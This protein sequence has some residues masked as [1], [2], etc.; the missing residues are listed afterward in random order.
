MN[1]IGGLGLALLLAGCVPPGAPS[2]TARIDPPADLLADADTPRVDGA[3]NTRFDE[4][5]VWEVRPVEPSAAASAGG[6]YRVQPG[7]TLRA[8][9]E[10]TG[11]G[12]EALARINNLAPPFLLRPGQILTVP[13]GRF[14]KVA[15]GE[16]G[17]AIARAYGIAWSEIVDANA[18]TEPFVLRIGQRLL[19]PTVARGFS[20]PARISP[21][22]RA[23]A[24][25]LD[26]DSL[27]TGGEPATEDVGIAA[28]TNPRAPLPAGVAVREPARFVGGFVWPVTGKIVQRFGPAG[29]GAV[30][31]GIDV[32]VAPG[33]NIRA[34]ASGVVAFVGD[35]V[36][37]Y[38]GL[39]LVRHG[40]GWITAYGRIARAEVTR[41]QAIERGQVLGQAGRGTNPQLFFQIR[42]NRVPVD[43]LRQLPA[44]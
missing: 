36:A 43:P 25:R 37:N 28:A 22:A 41:G 32:A 34:A 2:Q 9:G 17:I 14:H 18:L 21:E 11:A 3:L 6:V 30:S 12:S 15:A 35:R 7:D 33:A 40:D 10:K 1:R 8:V 4:Q 26:I 31:Q 24:F 16:T 29:T 27:I 20:A 44:R 39:V 13:E 23:A 19:L 5:P 42:K 38:G